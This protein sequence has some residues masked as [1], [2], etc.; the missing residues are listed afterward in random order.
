MSMLV[1]IAMFG[2]I[3]AVLVLFSLLPP[4]RAVIAA[5]L[6]AWLFLPVAAYPVQG[7]PDYD[8]MFAAC[9][10]VLLGVL[11]FDST[12]VSEFRLHW[13]DL[14][15]I[16]WC[17]VP[18]IS[19]VTN[20]LGA[21]DGASAVLK[22][23]VTW[24]LPYLIGR[25][26][27]RTTDDLRELAIGFFIG[28]L[29]YVPFC[30]YEIKMSPQLHRMVYGYHVSF[31]NSKRFEGWRPA[32]FMQDGL[33]VGMWMVTASLAGIWLWFTPGYSEDSWGFR[34]PGLC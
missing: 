3:P 25:L 9:T 24:G 23:L 10:G 27:F 1:P 17:L 5:F 29:L 28:G 12:R 15:M 32:V 8:K 21:Y 16:I 26:Y 30:L 20:G 2:W 33:M 14:P 6:G 18:F 34:P 4:R 19:S 11:L 31:A 7:L 13:L 22:T